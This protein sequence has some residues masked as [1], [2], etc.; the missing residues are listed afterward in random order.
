MKLPSFLNQVVTS[1]FSRIDRAVACASSRVGGQ[2]SHWQVRADKRGQIG[3]GA[4][5]QLTQITRFGA[6]RSLNFRPT[7]RKQDKQLANLRAT[8]LP[9]FE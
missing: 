9:G 1:A 5:P 7:L 6:P 4:Y 2:W 3:S 8:G